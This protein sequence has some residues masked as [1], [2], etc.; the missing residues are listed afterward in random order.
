MRRWKTRPGM[1]RSVPATRRTLTAR[2]TRK[3]LRRGDGAVLVETALVLPIL[4]LLFLGMFEF[5]RAMYVRLALR[6]AVGEAARYAV[7]GN[8]MVDEVTG[9]PIGRAASIRRVVVDASPTL[10]VS[11]DRIEIEPADGG[12]PEEIVSVRVTYEYRYTLPG[13]KDMLPPVEFTATAVMRNE[14][15]RP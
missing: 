1:A 14:P 8:E 9:D 2:R 3:V 15:F 6:H 12:R 11:P 5:G 13:L 4:M 10:T 7:T